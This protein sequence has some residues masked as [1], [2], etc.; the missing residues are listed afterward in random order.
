M[1]VYVTMLHGE[2]LVHRLYYIAHIGTSF[3]MAVTLEQPSDSFFNYNLQSWYHACASIICRS[4]TLFMWIRAYIADL[5][6]TVDKESMN[7]FTKKKRKAQVMVH[8][9]SIFVSILLFL[10]TLANNENWA[11]SLDNRC[12]A[13]E[14]RRRLGSTY[15]SYGS[16]SYS[17]SYSSYSPSSS[18]YS[19]GSSYASS[20]SS[21]SSAFGGAAEEDCDDGIDERWR[22][23]MPVTVLWLTA[24]IV[25]TVGSAVA[26]I[27]MK[28]PFAGDYAGERMQ[29]WLMLCFGESV[30]ALL[31]EP[32]YYASSEIGALL[33]AFTMIL[34]LCTAYFDIVDAD[35]FLHLF[36][37]RREK[38][39]SVSY[40]LIQYPFSVVVFLTGVALKI[41]MFTKKSVFQKQLATGCNVGDHETLSAHRRLLFFDIMRTQAVEAEGDEE[42]QHHRR[43]AGAWAIDDLND[44]HFKAFLLLCISVS[45]VMTT[46]LLIGCRLRLWFFCYRPIAPV[47]H[48]LP[49]LYFHENN[50]SFSCTSITQ[51]A[52]PISLPP[53]RVHLSRIGAIIISCL[54]LL[55]P[56]NLRDLVTPCLAASEEAHRRLAGSYSSYS[57]FDSSE[58]DDDSLENDEKLSTTQGLVTVSMLILASFIVALGSL[59]HKREE[60][61]KC[62]SSELI[63]NCIACCDFNRSSRH[64]I[65]V[66]TKTKSDAKLEEEAQEEA[67]ARFKAK[68]E[69]RMRKANLVIGVASHLN[70]ASARISKERNEASSKGE[71]D[72]ATVAAGALLKRAKQPQSGA[73]NKGDLV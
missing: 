21:Y 34:C 61:C 9:G 19:S 49:F 50:N 52:M 22:H 47:S 31:V 30:I 42:A 39:K 27:Y 35:Q 25:E 16:S 4:V 66:K 7:A 38:I 12:A 69:K 53:W 32:I 18:S 11:F 59:D 55:I 23:H 41:I 68:M 8:A 28:L 72:G 45:L 46:S 44:L 14:S 24:I 63:C 57:S 5:E 43:L 73:P 1:N 33:A 26:A 51:D 40:M 17:S 65:Y 2:D 60:S 29:A 10:V 6:A 37:V 67:A 58:F 48:A 64:H 15:S 54:T 71:T 36:I 13:G 56:F 70:K 20:Y 62:F 3:V